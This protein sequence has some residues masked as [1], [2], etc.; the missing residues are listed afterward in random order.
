M[1]NKIKK[2]DIANKYNDMDY[3]WNKNDSWH[4][5]TFL[6]IKKNLKALSEK[7]F[8][9]AKLILNAGSAGNG[10]ELFLDQ[11]HLDISDKK[12]ENIENAIVADVCDIP[13]EN[14]TFDVCIC[15][16]SVV[17]YCDVVQ[18]IKELKR[19][20]VPG[21]YVIIEYETSNSLE[22]K[23]TPY[24]KKN[25]GL[26]STFYNGQEEKI[27]VYSQ[28]YINSI[29]THLNLKKIEETGFHLFTSGAYNLLHSEEKAIKFTCWDF[30][31][32][33]KLFRRYAS[34]IILVCRKPF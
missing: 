12:L 26:A 13:I 9:D 11:I 20:T 28:D 14:D 2:E 17:N 16:G 10:Y 3:I 30:L 19:V 15:V 21:G 22:Y 32:K 6:T 24:Y 5:Y 33:V 7:Y 23:K 27:Y 25:V 34:N 29:L 8:Q 1:E 18:A 31:T 4:Y